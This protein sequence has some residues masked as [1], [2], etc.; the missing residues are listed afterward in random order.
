M[1]WRYEENFGPTGINEDYNCNVNVISMVKQ[2]K[3]A[4]KEAMGLQKPVQKIYHKAKKHHTA[5][6][7]FIILAKNKLR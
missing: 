5:V 3:I 4:F 7:L 1:N 6:S 2:G